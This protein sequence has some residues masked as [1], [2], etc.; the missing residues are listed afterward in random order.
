MDIFDDLEEFA[1]NLG[2]CDN[3]KEKLQKR[4]PEAVISIVPAEPFDL[5]ENVVACCAS[6]VGEVVPVK[7]LTHTS[8]SQKDDVLLWAIL[9]EIWTSPFASPSNPTSWELFFWD[10]VEDKEVL[11][12]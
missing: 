6:G 3:A 12:R 8:A 10:T 11:W 2:G 5:P 1:W 7:R 9:E 4:Y